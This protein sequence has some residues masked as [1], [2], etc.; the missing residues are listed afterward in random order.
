MPTSSPWASD[1]YYKFTLVYTHTAS[2]NYGLDLISIVFYEGVASAGS[3]KTLVLL[4][5]AFEIG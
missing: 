2:K 1:C 3:T 5:I 4:D